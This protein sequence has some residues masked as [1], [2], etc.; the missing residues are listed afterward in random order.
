MSPDLIPL[1]YATLRV[2]WWI[3]MGVLLVG[4]GVLGGADL[5]VGALLPFVARHDAERRVAINSIGPTWE[6]NQVWFILGGGAVFA[7]WPAVYAAAFSV[8]YSV[9]L[10]L[11]LALILRPVG[12]EY[13]NKLRNGRWRATWDLGLVIG[14]GV[15][16]FLFGAAMGNLLQGVPIRLD[17]TMRL[18][19]EGSV[20]GLLNPFAILCGLVSLS[21]LVMHGGMFLVMKTE[22]PVRERA[23]TAV[24][25][26]TCALI[27]LFGFAGVCVFFW[28]KGYEIAGAN[29]GGPSNPLTKTV[30]RSLGAWY[31]NYAKNGWLWI[32][33][34]LGFGGAVFG[35]ILATIRQGMIGFW[36]TGLSVAGVIATAGVSMFP[37]I[38]PS[39]AH[40]AASLTVWDA[41]SSPLTL[42]M[43]LAAVVL[44]M[45]LVLIYTG[46]VLRLMRGKVNEK[47]VRENADALY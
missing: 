27:M 25:W 6:G 5:G 23:R 20:L 40:L 10:V 44:L 42:F 19:Y 17:E 39:R 43:M 16:A 38:L 35:F 11:L 15:P 46:W 13:R 12:F 47:Y 31:T 9:M 7:A 45:P 1:D 36:F 29:P 8:F 2:L 33:P 34:G 37:F 21:M 4:F 32:A 22:G 41:S 3:I 18:T 30:T 28:I 26:S 14:G 24:R